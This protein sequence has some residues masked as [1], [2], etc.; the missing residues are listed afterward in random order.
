[1]RQCAAHAVGGEQVECWLAR[2]LLCWHFNWTLAELGPGLRAEK[3]VSN[4]PN[5]RVCRA[6]F[7]NAAELTHRGQTP[8]NV[9]NSW[10]DT[11]VSCLIRKEIVQFG[12][13]YCN[14]T[15]W[16]EIGDYSKTHMAE[17]TYSWSWALLEEPPIL[18]LLKNFPAFYGTRSFITVFTRALHWSVYWARSIQSIPSHL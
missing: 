11:L 1:M 18:Q 12:D 10:C 13:A 2:N 4:P 9:S 15:K 5:Y 17:H 14:I 7:Y 6:R 3:P 8:S 16:K